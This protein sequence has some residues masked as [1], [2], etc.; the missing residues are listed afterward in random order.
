[1]SLVKCRPMKVAIVN[2]TARTLWALWLMGAAIGRS[3]H[4]NLSRAGAVSATLSRSDGTGATVVS[5]A[6]QKVEA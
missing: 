5:S 4:H 2:K 6:S 1:M 3:K